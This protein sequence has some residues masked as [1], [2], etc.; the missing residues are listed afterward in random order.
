MAAPVL[1]DAR[2][3]FGDYALEYVFISLHPV[4]AGEMERLSRIVH[5]TERLL[6]QLA[7][8]AS[9]GDAD[10]SELIEKARALR[11][12]AAAI[13]AVAGLD[14]SWDQG[15]RETIVLSARDSAAVVQALIEPPEPNDALRQAL[16]EYKAIVS[17]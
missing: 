4:T 3:Q 7:P 12:G 2:R 13:L 1:D 10:L 16:K 11:A 15:V 5:G 6:A 14:S 9:H 8:S 17:V